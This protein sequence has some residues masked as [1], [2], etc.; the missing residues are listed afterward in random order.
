MTAQPDDGTALP[1][2][3][4]PR[5]AYVHVPFCAHHCGYCDFAVAVGQDEQMERYLDALA[6]E[7]TTLEKPQHVETLFLGGGTPTYLPANLLARLLRLVRDWLPVNPGGEISI[8]A[9]PGTLDEE[10]I[11]VLTAHGVNRVSLGAQSFHPHV[12]RVLERDHQPPDV[13]QA[14]ERLRGR[15]AAVSLDLIFGV[16]GQS[17]DDWRSDL[18]QALRLPI[19]H[20]STYGLTYEKGT[21]LWKQRRGG[22]VQALSEEAELEQYLLAMDMLG[23]AG[24]EHYEISSFARPGRRCRH[25]QVYWANHAY[26]GF[27]M[28]AAR[29]VQG[30]RQLNT[31]SLQGYLRRTLA[32][33]PAMMQ[34]EQLGSEERARETISV[35]L[36]R[37]EGI[38]RQAFREQTSFSLD[39]LAGDTVARQ[40]ELGL[41]VD[42]GERV[43]FSRRGKCVAD[44]VVREIW[45]SS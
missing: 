42:D 21:R 10:R 33:K 36:R 45:R 11:A 27:G 13:P 34:S 29:Y 9:N 17:L 32:G 15:V 8:E 2:W 38:D 26:F 6:A 39:N 43:R 35:Q 14:V 28:G 31:R 19:D 18:E 20:V 22:Q 7:L 3:L 44:A 12:L 23:A 40:V 5:A 24:F 1:P 41:L 4:W 30:R 25:N 37:G 16:P